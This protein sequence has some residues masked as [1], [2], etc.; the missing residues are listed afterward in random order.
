MIDYF[1]R[2]YW[3][4][5]NK[6][7]LALIF[8]TIVIGFAFCLVEGQKIQ[9]T[10]VFWKQLLG[11]IVRLEILTRKYEYEWDWIRWEFHLRFCLSLSLTKNECEKYFIIFW[12]K[13]IFNIF[14]RLTSKLLNQGNLSHVIKCQHSMAKWKFKSVCVFH[15]NLDEKYHINCSHWNKIK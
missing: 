12:I 4:E 14:L 9:F 2:T 10:I 7:C 11:A 6:K 13:I 3:K 1:D 8:A 15:C 5:K